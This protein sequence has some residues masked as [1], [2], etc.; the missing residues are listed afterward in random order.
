MTH[1][2]K[3]LDLELRDW[4]NMFFWCE[5]QFG[6]YSHRWNAAEL[7]VDDKCVELNLNLNVVFKFDHNEDAVQFKMR[8]L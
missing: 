2:V 7:G 6:T 4:T 1:N 8:W 5:E 3:M